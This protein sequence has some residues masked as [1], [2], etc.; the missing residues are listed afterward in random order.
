MGDNR[1]NNTFNRS[2]DT[3]L[4]FFTY[5][6]FKPGQL[7]Y[8]KIKYYIAEKNEAE[9]NH[10]MK[11]RDG[12]PILIPNENEGTR[13]VGYVFHFNDNEKAYEIINETISNRLYEWG[14]INIGTEEVNVLFGKRPYVG[15][16][17]IESKS[18]RKNFNGKNDPL[19]KE[20]IELI[21][22]NL[23]SENF[24]WEK[25]FFKLQMNYMLL[26]SAID[27]YCKL[28]Y[29]KEREH[30]N[31][32]EL[33]KEKVFE[34]ALCIYANERKFRP[35]YTTDD[36]TKRE[37]DIGNPKYC[38]NYY[39][40]LRCNIVHRGKTSMR[41]IDLLKDATNDLLNIFDYILKDTFKE[42]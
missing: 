35:I 16:N 27:R 9:I 7:A 2:N 41:D 26:W 34:E 28:K 21:K 8:S 10:I 32:E 37:F 19:F 6:I 14:T 15:S 11:H 38:M 22:E 20:G 23:E 5:G 25:G 39:Y 18:D 42:D 3:N 36:L 30:E 1:N 40:T 24:S 4:P 17:D 12:V 31:R 33:S 29:N 13:T